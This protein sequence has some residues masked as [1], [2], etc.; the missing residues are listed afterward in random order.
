MDRSRPSITD[1]FGNFG[2]LF[3]TFGSILLNSNISSGVERMMELVCIHESE[4]HKEWIDMDKVKSFGR[5]G[6]SL[7][8][9]NGRKYKF[10]KEAWYELCQYFY[11][12]IGE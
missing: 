12:P 9:V 11:V 10:K 2:L 1:M 7:L 4:H 8:F 3:G 5:Y 6:D